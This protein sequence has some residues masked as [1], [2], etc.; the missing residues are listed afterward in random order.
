MPGFLVSHKS[1][2]PNSWNYKEK[3]L[4]WFPKVSFLWCGFQSSLR[5]EIRGANFGREGCFRKK[6]HSDDKW[7]G[8]TIKR[9]FF[10]Q[11]R[12]VWGKERS[13]GIVGAKASKSKRKLGFYFFLDM[14]VCGLQNLG[15][16]HCFVLCWSCALELGIQPSFSFTSKQQQS[17]NSPTFSGIRVLGITAH[18][19]PCSFSQALCVC[20]CVLLSRWV[21]KRLT[22]LER[23]CLPHET[24]MCEIPHTNFHDQPWVHKRPR[25][26]HAF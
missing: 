2:H 19:G 13:F 23:K 16:H 17:G 26:C 1:R 20:V 10:Q 22:R 21:A 15:L 25:I 6:L 14:A 3:F 5:G 4:P 18:R 12:W 9:D 24:R 11:L 7:F 8:R